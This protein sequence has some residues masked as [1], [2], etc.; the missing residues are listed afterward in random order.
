MA[1]CQLYAQQPRTTCPITRGRCSERCLCISDLSLLIGFSCGATKGTGG[2]EQLRDEIRRAE[3]GG[4]LHSPRPGP[5]TA[6]TESAAASHAHAGAVELD[7]EKSYAFTCLLFS[8]FQFH[9]ID[10]TLKIHLMLQTGYPMSHQ[11][12]VPCGLLQTTM[13]FLVRD[14]VPPH[15]VI[16]G[17]IML[18]CRLANVLPQD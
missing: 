9:F 13:L 11:T 8:W 4:I 3:R 2:L 7:D 15:A 5:L 1:L 17:I 16:I 6:W 12:K 10:L 18:N 14:A